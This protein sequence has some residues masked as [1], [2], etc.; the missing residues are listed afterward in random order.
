MPYDEKLAARVR[1][2]LSDRND[3]TERAIFVGPEGSNGPAVRRWVA[4]AIA[5]A[6]SRPPKRK[7]AVPR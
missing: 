3:V 2:L 6:E 5:Y 4:V 1:R 7:K